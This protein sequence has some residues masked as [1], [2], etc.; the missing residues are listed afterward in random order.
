MAM[1]GKRKEK[2]GKGKRVKGLNRFFTTAR[3]GGGM[4]EMQNV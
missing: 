3:K 4:I 2:K 1:T